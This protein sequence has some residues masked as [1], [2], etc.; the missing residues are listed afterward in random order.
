MDEHG[1]SA[2]MMA[3]FM[4]STPACEVGFGFRVLG[5]RVRV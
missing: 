1:V 3:A 2:L 5:I 4:G